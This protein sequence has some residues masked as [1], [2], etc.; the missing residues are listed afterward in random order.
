MLAKLTLTITQSVIEEAK[1]YAQK[2]NKS[3]SR[4]VEEYLKNITTDH[5][6][7]TSFSALKSPITDSLSGMFR[8]IGHRRVCLFF[9][10]PHRRDNRK[11]VLFRRNAKRGCRFYR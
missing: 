10:T 1:K 8:D 5:D 2:K 6:S 4:I 3:V 7:V 9:K 11:A